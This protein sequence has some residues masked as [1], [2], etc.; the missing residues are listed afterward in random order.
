MH[1]YAVGREDATSLGQRML[2]AEYFSDFKGGPT[3]LFWGNADGMRHLIVMIESMP[4]A[5]SD[6]VLSGFLNDAPRIILRSAVASRGMQKKQDHLF[7]WVLDPR[8]AADFCDKIRLVATANFPAHNYLEANEAG[9][10]T[11][12][13]SC[14]EYPSDL[15]PW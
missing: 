5:G 12:T 4:T 14:G 13:V 11:V 7:E 10:I 6:V 2:R 3:L 1:R 8:V 15:K 9:E